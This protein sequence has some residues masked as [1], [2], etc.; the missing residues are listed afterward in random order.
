MKL[1]SEDER[2]ILVHI[3]FKKKAGR[4]CKDRIIKSFH[5]IEFK[6]ISLF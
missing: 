5:I 1:E 4:K 3:N 2:K 6:D